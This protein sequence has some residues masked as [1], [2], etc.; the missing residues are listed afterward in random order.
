MDTELIRAIARE[1]L[2][3]A[4]V[5]D[6][7][8]AETAHRVTSLLTKV[9][10]ADETAMQPLAPAIAFDPVHP[11]YR[12]EP[13]APSVP[14]DRMAQAGGGTGYSGA[15]GNTGVTEAYIPAGSAPAESV[16]PEYLWWSAADLAEAI[17]S[18]DLSPVEVTRA[19]LERISAV[20]PKLNAFVTVM[21]EQAMED[22]RRAEQ[23]E[24]I[25]PLHGVPVAL[26]DLFEVSGVRTT[27][28]SRI[29]AEHISR[30]DATVVTRL[31]EAGAIILGKT[32][33]HEFA[34]GALTDSPF[35]GP[36]HNPWDLSRIPGGSSGG[37]G[38]AVAAGLAPVAM[39][40]D[41]GG[42]VRMPAALCSVVGLKPTYGRV[43]KAGVLPLSWSLDHVGPLTRTVRDAALVLEAIAGPDP[44]DPTASPQPV[45]DYVGAARADQ[46]KGVRIGLPAAWLDGPID[47]GVTAAFR[48]A[49]DRLR[50]LGAEVVEVTLPPADVMT[51]VN[52][53][54][55]LAEAGA[56]HAPYLKDR[57]ELYSP[58]VRLRM[59]LGQYML[60]RDYLAGQ[61]LRGEITRHVY[62]VMAGVDALAT[63]SIPIA[64]ALIGQAVWEYPDGRREPVPEAMIRF[65]APFSVTGQP[66]IS[67][68]CGFTPEGLPVGLQLVGRT[69]DEAGLIR[70]A[71]AFE[72]A[73]GPARRP[74]L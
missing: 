14:W 19:F 64:P 33:T 71:A 57:A 60:A 54:L 48:T 11:A 31:R 63:P 72:A 35:H 22:A 34:F 40:T 41:T 13:I 4:D 1:M 38:A 5:D 47:P 9:R 23:E 59:E 74:M 21:A 52:R 58:D 73:G 27:G 42:S 30:Q 18:R 45:D 12:A 10:L 39:G 53:L 43:S 50:S 17:R 7:T 55:A 32:A 49:L 16:G 29:L 2:G 37:S 68:P 61:R 56:Y 69:F 51:F 20:D 24:P 28:G 44:L 15:G 6:A 66:A 67:V 25:G 26:K 62:Q 65:A 36:V 46:L 3:R 8:L 70:I